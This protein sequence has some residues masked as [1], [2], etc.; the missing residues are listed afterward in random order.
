MSISSDVV[1]MIDS[2]NELYTGQQATPEVL[3]S[4]LKELRAY[5]KRDE[6]LVIGTISDAYMWLGIDEPMGNGDNELQLTLL[7]PS[8]PG[9]PPTFASN[10][11]DATE[12]GLLEAI[13]DG[14]EFLKRYHRDG[15]CE[16]KTRFVW[17]LKLE[18]GTHCLQCTANKAMGM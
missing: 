10:S 16:C 3:K 17:R 2:Y 6:F 8:G 4:M 5:T 13:V 18:G 11:Y 12:Q 7:G 9:G 14:K 1:A 15:V